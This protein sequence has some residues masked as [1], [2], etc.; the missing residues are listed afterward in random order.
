MAQDLIDIWLDWNEKRIHSHDFCMAFEKEFRK[1]I[2]E[3]I[4]RKQN[5]KKKILRQMVRGD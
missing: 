1:E 3:R 4:Q 2:R 5:L